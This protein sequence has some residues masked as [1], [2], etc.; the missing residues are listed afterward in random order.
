M[1]IVDGI[2]EKVQKKLFTEFDVYQLIRLIIIVGGYIFLRTR[3]TEYLKNKQLRDQI[4][5]DKEEKARKLVNDPTGEGA[6]AEAEEMFQEYDGI[7]KSEQ[8]WG[9]GK[10]TR[11]R[12]KKQQALFEKEIERAAVE[13]QRKLDNNYDSD[14]EINELLQ[15]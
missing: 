15:D 13:A 1:G 8:G 3:A 4:E 2:I 9:W 12:V 10:A 7:K 14:E 6:R 11:K 5:K